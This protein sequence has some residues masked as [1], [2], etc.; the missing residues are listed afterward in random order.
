VEVSFIIR[1]K[2]QI[3]DTD[4]ALAALKA[5]IDGCVDAGIVKDDSPEYLTYKMP[6]KWEVDKQRAPLTVLTFREIE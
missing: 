3:R 6:I 4:N 5:G 2:K 1:N